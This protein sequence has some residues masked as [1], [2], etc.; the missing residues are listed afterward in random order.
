MD[1]R[2]D[3]WAVGAVMF[4]LLSGRMVREAETVPE[5]LAFAVRDPAPLLSSVA[6]GVPDRVA[7]IVDRALSYDKNQRFQDA[8]SMQ[9][10]VREALKMVG[11]PETISVAVRA[12]SSQRLAV[13]DADTMLA[14]SDKPLPPTQQTLS[15]GGVAAPPSTLASGNSTRPRRSRAPW[16]LLAGLVAGFAVVTTF[17]KGRGDVREPASSLELEQ[18]PPGDS[19]P[20]APEVVPLVEMPSASPT[21][22]AGSAAPAASASALSSASKSAT[23][24]PVRRARAGESKPAATTPSAQPAA[25]K[26]P[27][28]RAGNPFDKRF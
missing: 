26:N 22:D 11:R 5:Q 16:L 25:P 3:L 12:T 28:P 20:P 15:T 24:A 19:R 2:T 18:V 23:P 13:H 14:S 21:S 8:R 7:E 27:P 10:A 9:L 4:V 17:L 6:P 1:A